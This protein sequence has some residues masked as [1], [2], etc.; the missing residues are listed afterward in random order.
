MVQQ[1]EAWLNKHGLLDGGK[2][3]ER[4][5]WCTDGV[6]LRIR[7]YRREIDLRDCSHGI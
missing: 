4:A 1:F 6:S 3:R 7:D 5:C 2:L